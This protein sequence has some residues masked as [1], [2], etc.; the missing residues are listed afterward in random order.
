MAKGYDVIVI[1]AGSFGMS[2][3]YYL[4]RA[5][6]RVLLI[7]AYDPP[8][9]QGSHHGQTRIFRAAY[10]MGPAYVA[11]ALRARHLW[12]QLEE[13]VKERMG[14]LQSPAGGH[15]VHSEI[16]RQ[17]GVVSIGEAESHFLKSKRQSCEA[18]GIPFQSLKSAELTALWP[19]FSVPEWAEALY[20]PEAGILY[21]E[22]IIRTYRALAERSGAELLVH[23]RATHIESGPADQA[24]HTT[25]GIYHAA[26]VLVCGG[27]WSAELLP[28]LRG[29]VNPVRKAIGWFDAPQALYG[30]DSFPAFIVNKG[31]GE[32]YFGIPDVDGEGLKIGRHDG[33]E[34]LLPDQL[35]A[36]FGAYPEDK[37]DLQLFIHDYLPK[38]QGFSK[39]N[40]CLY[41]HAPGEQFIIDRIPDRPHVWF[42]GGGSGHGFKFASSIGEALSQLL[43]TGQSECEVGSWLLG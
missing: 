15:P 30:H 7:D 35:I 43:L 27:A 33:G 13:E 14:N 3:C 9:D 2:A 22:N 41:E 20:E 18:F 5:G 11:L 28:E 34:F 42:A 19:G 6:A 26:Q 25:K 38:V 29:V 1:G 4:A 36:P 32:E 24:V 16:F 21:S 12:L 40:I 8:H 39:G 10:T 37:Q 23:T 31:G 17:T